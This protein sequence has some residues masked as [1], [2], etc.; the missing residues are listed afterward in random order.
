VPHN[1]PNKAPDAQPSMQVGSAL[2]RGQ[3]RPPQP[4]PADPF[5]VPNPSDPWRPRTVP[6]PPS[7]QGR[8]AR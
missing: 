5:P 7:T 1:L 6:F 2:Y 3:P 8:W 4:S